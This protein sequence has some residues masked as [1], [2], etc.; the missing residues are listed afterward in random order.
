MVER[1]S[2]PLY[3]KTPFLENV[4]RI[5]LKVFTYAAYRRQP[6]EESLEK[7]KILPKREPKPWMAA[8]VASVKVPRIQ[9]LQKP[10]LLQGLQR[11]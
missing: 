11:L 1:S 2:I 5:V 3:V 7:R 10:R 4:R 6:T 8:M 9:R